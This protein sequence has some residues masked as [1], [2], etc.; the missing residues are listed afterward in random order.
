MKINAIITGSTGMVGKG[1]LLECLEN[2]LVESVLVINRR[3]LGIK[4]PKMKEI[5]HSDFMDLSDITLQLRGYNACF[6]CMG[7][8]SAGLSEEKYNRITYDYTLNFAKI[9]VRLNPEMTFC[10]ISGA[11]TDSTEKGRTMWA[12]VKGRTENA[13]L[14]IGFKSAFMF[15]PGFIKPRKGIRSRT[16]MYNVI[17]AL[18][19][20]LYPVLKSFPGFVTD[21]KTLAQAMMYVVNNGYPKKILE[22][23]D[24][25][26]AGNINV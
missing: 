11:G 20:P 25:N 22:S 2:N 26:Q 7:V 15:R 13:L 5:I 19:G 23:R 14:N 3:P 9:L 12:R 4:H 10:F 6:F 17:Y 16:A 8:S 1:I 18:I 21:T 24:I